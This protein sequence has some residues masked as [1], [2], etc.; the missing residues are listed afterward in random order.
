[1]WNS[2]A[3]SSGT[4]VGPA[5]ILPCRCAPALLLIV[6]G[7]GNVAPAAPSEF[8][9]QL[10]IV[11]NLA[12]PITVAIDGEPMVILRSGGSSGLTVSSNAQWLTWVSAKPMDPLGQPIQDDIGSVQHAIGGINRTLAVTNII[13]DQPH[14]TAEVFNRTSAPVSIGVFD[15]ARVACAA[16]LPARSPQRLGYTRTGYYRLGGATEM[17]AYRDPLGCTGPYVAWPAAQLRSYEPGSGLISLVLD[18]EP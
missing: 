15:G 14:I 6:A 8:P 12:A 7:C 13:G 11:N 16:E 4:L 10:R 2:T 18:A 5:W 3:G 1:M 9:V 17:R